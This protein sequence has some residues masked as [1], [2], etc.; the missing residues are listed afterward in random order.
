MGTLVGL[1]VVDARDLHQRSCLGGRVMLG[2]M[3]VE[4]RRKRHAPAENPCRRR[5]RCAIGSQQS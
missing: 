3:R 1:E 2:E 5:V 4:M